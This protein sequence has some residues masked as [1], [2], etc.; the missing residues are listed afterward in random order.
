MERRNSRRIIRSKEE[1]E[2]EGV[3]AAQK[4]EVEEKGEE[5]GEE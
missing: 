1:E 2:Y 3:R 5:E 4:E